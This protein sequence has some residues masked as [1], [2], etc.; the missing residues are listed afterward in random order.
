[1][2]DSFDK[3]MAICN[4]TRDNLGDFNATNEQL[5][6]SKQFEKDIIASLWERHKKKVMSSEFMDMFGFF[7]DRP[8]IPTD[9]NGKVFMGIAIKVK[10][11]EN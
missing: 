4:A 5:T 2:M 11:N 7:V 1:M 10:E 3:F 6:I 8:D 9:L